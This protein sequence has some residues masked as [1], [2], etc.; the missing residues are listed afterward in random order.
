MTITLPRLGLALTALALLVSA[1]AS[2][3]AAGEARGNQ[4]TA[5]DRNGD[6]IPDRWERRHRLSLRVNQARRD[7]DHDG[8]RNREEFLSGTSPRDRDSDDDGIRDGH[9]GAG[10]IVSFV[11]GVL[12]IEPFGT[13]EALR[14]KVDAVTE[15]KCELGAVAVATSSSG[16]DDDEGDD[17]DH[18]DRRDG[19][20]R[21]GDDGPLHDAGDDRRDRSSG[22][23]GDRHD[24]DD[25]RRPDCAVTLADLIPGAIVHEAELE[26][27]SGGAVW[28]EVELVRPRPAS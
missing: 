1:F 5:G 22:H 16:G 8:L 18:S 10:R 26:V 15:L 21:Q 24:D 23:D 9:E 20:G 25:D 14:G 3:P 4:R 2:L 11:G 27:R 6:R 12:T 17:D 7:Q 28:D 19:E 13:T